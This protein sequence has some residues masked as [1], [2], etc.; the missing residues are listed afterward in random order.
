MPSLLSSLFTGVSGLQAKS[1]AMGI[2][3][4]NISNVN[5]VGFKS[6]RAVFSDLF[7]TILANGSFLPKRAVDLE[8]ILASLGGPKIDLKRNLGRK[9]G[10]RRM[11]F[12]DFSTFLV[13]LGFPARFWFDF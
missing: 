7:S 10:H 11:I 9:L 3:G 4:D 8:L 6:S 1:E 5:T 13:F 12:I 2:L